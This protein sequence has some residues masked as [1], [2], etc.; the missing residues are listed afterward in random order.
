MVMT[1]AEISMANRQAT[2]RKIRK[3][4]PVFLCFCNVARYKGF[5]LSFDRLFAL[6]NI[7]D[8]YLKIYDVALEAQEAKLKKIRPGLMA[9]EVHAAG[10]KVYQ[11]AGFGTASR[12]GHGIGYSFVEKPS[13]VDGEKT[14]LKPGM[15]LAVNEFIPLRG[16]FAAHLGDSVVVTE[17]GYEFLF[18]YPRNLRIL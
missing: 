16:E 12:S 3:G 7:P 8:K 18:E 13:L 9:E 1:G 5:K 11:N 15:T 10:K 17:T 6:G 4:D 2:V 14:I